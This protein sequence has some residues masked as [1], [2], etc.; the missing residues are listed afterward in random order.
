M[1]NNSGDISQS[2]SG[3]EIH[4]GMQAAQGNNILQLQTEQFNLYQLNIY[5]KESTTETIHKANLLRI[6]SFFH[7]GMPIL[8]EFFTGREE[9]IKQVITA[10]KEVRIISILG[11]PGIGK[12]SLM[13]KLA[14][15]FEPK[16]VFWF[17]FRDGLVSLDSIISCL[18]QFLDEDA[19]E[20]EKLAQIFQLNLCSENEKIALLIKRLNSKK[21]YL[22]FDSIHYIGN[23]TKISSFFSIL[24]QN[25]TQGNVFISS[26]LK[27]SFYKKLDEVKKAVKVFSL[28]GLNKEETEKLFCY[29][30]IELSQNLIDEIYKQLKGFPLSLQLVIELLRNGLNQSKLIEL[31]NQAKEE[32]TQELFYE[33][34]KH[35][36]P[37]EKSLLT[38]SSLFSFPFKE[39][40]S[41]Q[42]SSFLFSSENKKESF[43]ELKRKLL[44][45]ESIDGRYKVHEIIR[46]LALTYSNEGLNEYL[47]RLADY[48]SSRMKAYELIQLEVILLYYRAEEYD[49]AAEIGLSAIQQGLIPYHAELAEI[50]LNGFQECNVSPEVWVWIVGC[51]G[52]LSNFWGR[53]DEAKD[54]YQNMLEIANKLNDKYAISVAFQRLGVIYAAEDFK[55]S[56]KYYLDALSLKKEL[57][58]IEGQSQ[59]YNNLGSLYLNQGQWIKAQTSLEKAL[60]LLDNSNAADWERLAVYGNLATMYAGRKEWSKT[61]EFRAKV[62]TIA[63]RE[64]LPYDLARSLYNSGIDRNKQ[65]KQKEAK[66]YYLLALEIANKH[67]LHDIQALVYNALARQSFE[68]ED[69]CTSINWFQELI[70][71]QERAKNFMGLAVTSF[72]I[73]YVFNCLGDLSQ[74]NVFYGNAVQILSELKSDRLFCLALSGISSI[75]SQSSQPKLVI[76]GLRII[77]K[78]LSNQGG[79][80]RLAKVCESISQIYLSLGLASISKKYIGKSACFFRDLG[81]KDEYIG[82]LINFAY[83]CEK[84]GELSYAIKVNTEV[85]QLTKSFQLSSSASIAYY[86]RA[87]CYVCLEMWEEAEKDFKNAISICEMN[88]N[89][90]LLDS[91]LHNLGEMYRRCNRSKSAVKMLNL[92][93]NYSRKREDIDAEIIA[94]NN[95][96]LAYEELSEYEKALGCFTYALDLCQRQH[97][98]SEE[99][100]VLISLGNYYFRK[101]QFLEAKQY[102]EKAFNIACFIEDIEAEE[103]AILSLAYVHRKLDTFE[104]IADEFK[105]IAE[106]SGEMENYENLLSFLIFCGEI[107]FEKEDALTSSNM[108]GKALIVSFYLMMRRMQKQSGIDVSPVLF[109]DIITQVTTP[110]IEEIKSAV[111]LGKTDNAKILYTSLVEMM[112]ESGEAGNWVL[113]YCLNRIGYHLNLLLEER[114]SL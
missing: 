12:S 18:V 60:N 30:N 39:D 5:Q 70:T 102:Y 56:E 64:N 110:I 90:Y 85:I 57:D 40:D 86:N 36:S 80:Y 84:E 93:L 77:R 37:D 26:R 79:I 51:K 38:T 61:E 82:V 108:F 8:E 76:R 9:L 98:K 32:V 3:S 24:K 68:M 91:A 19:E 96:G 69:F 59:V 58:D 112:K 88:G 47:V 25:L 99:S 42:A 75:A 81:F 6:N 34:Y 31:I 106:R 53:H 2:V 74:S 62:Q 66:N 46:N 109:A 1:P 67:N 41:I 92:S 100:N 43:L 52:I 14:H 17:E 95:L 49:K 7:S 21:A 10:T 13:V 23:D 83:A 48:F 29:F 28:D 87:N 55:Q 11:I 35:L 16:N 101:N 97:R 63:K 54:Y 78:S 111:T 4:G 45:Q 89:S 33:V 44:L 113:E 104:A 105:R 20:D 22:F 72:S 71:V 50:I 15:C 107:N 27:P 73:G 114:D 103:K 94:L 65:N